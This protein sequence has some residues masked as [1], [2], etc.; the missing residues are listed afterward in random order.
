MTGRHPLDRRGLPLPD[1]SWPPGRE[2][3]EPLERLRRFLN[4]TNRE[5]GAEALDGPDAA[6]AWLLTDGH[7]CGVLGDDDV[8]TLHQLR[9]AL[10]VL[11]EHDRAGDEPLRG[12][13]QTLERLSAAS[14]VRIRLIPSP[15][16]DSAA[17]GTRGVV[18][19]LL[20]IAYTAM[21]D[22]TWSRLKTCRHCHWAYYDRSRNQTG[23][24]CARAACGSRTKARAYRA[25]RRAAERAVAD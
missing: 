10:W 11:V 5:V 16:M 25:R 3:P 13:Q 2:A 12:A 17:D 18:G 9:D 19:R 1:P 24:W 7:S 20:G 22:G 14:P 15:G 6:R 8:A 21:A 4:T 23:A